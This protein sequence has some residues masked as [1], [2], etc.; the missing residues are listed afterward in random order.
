MTVTATLADGFAWTDPL[1]AGWTEVNPTTATFQVTL[2]APSCTPATPVAPTVVQA[3][4]TNGAVT[5]PTITPGPTPGVTYTLAPAGPYDGNVTTTVTVTATLAD[6]FAWTD[7]LPAGWTEVTPT[8][9]T[10]Q[11]TLTAATCDD[12]VP[13]APALVQAVC[14]GG[15]VTEPTLTLP[16][17]DGI[18]YTTGAAP[19]YAAGQT[20]VVTATLNE[21]FALPDALPAGW[22]ATSA[23]TATYRVTFAAASCVPVVP[24]DPAVTF[25]SCGASGVVPASVTVANTP[26]VTYSRDPTPALRPVRRDHGRGDGD[27]QRRV[28]LDGRDHGTGRVRQTPGRGPAGARGAG[29]ANRLDPDKPDHRN[30]HDHPAGV[31]HM[32]GNRGIGRGTRRSQ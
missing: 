14:V 17:T 32:S 7:P 31:A 29:A 23:T 16:A 20:V 12:V 3:T 30:V 10:F 26:G 11:I 24:V 27:T 19:P 22:N 4:C 25:A 6:G 15:D 2:T 5:P 9:A 13:V 28:R 21:G 1:P 18:T 8:T